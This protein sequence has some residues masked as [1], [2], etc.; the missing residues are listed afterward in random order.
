MT[1]QEY[2]ELAKRTDAPM[3]DTYPNLHAVHMVMGIS[4]EAGEL[5]DVYKKSLAYGKPIDVA[6]E[7]EEIGDLMWYIAN[8]CTNRGFDLSEIMATNIAKL[9][10]RYPEKFTSEN[11]ITRDLSKEREILEK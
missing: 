7:K 4:T 10:A 11:A 9:Q 6:N 8:H 1:I 2:S 5:V 3:G